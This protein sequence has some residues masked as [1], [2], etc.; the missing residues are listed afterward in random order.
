MY[1]LIR[2]IVGDMSA[3][4]RDGDMSPTYGPTVVLQRQIGQCRDMSFDMSPMSFDMSCVV[5]FGA[6][7][8]HVFKRHCQLSQPH[9]D[10]SMFIGTWDKGSKMKADYYTKHHSPSH[11]QLMRP[12]YL[13]TKNNFAALS[14]DI[15]HALRGCVDPN[16]SQ[17]R[18]IGTQSEQASH[19][20]FT[21]VRTRLTNHSEC[22][23][24]SLYKL[25]HFTH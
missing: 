15:M 19:F 7:K 16:P 22:H 18:I 5:S 6:S 23:R 10:S 9:R 14:H 3:T 20:P 17:S 24:Q 25:T 1:Q 13:H 2:R 12:Q 8:R 4:C 11:H 21:F